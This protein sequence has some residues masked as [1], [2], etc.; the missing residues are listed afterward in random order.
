LY[1]LTLLESVNVAAMACGLA[2]GADARSPPTIFL[3][4][5]LATVLGLWIDG[6]KEAF[7]LLF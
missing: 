2:G 6:F 3:T 7:L 4:T 1:Y 5:F